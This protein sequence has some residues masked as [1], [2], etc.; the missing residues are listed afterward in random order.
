MLQHTI[1]Q[2]FSWSTQDRFPFIPSWV[3]GLW[4]VFFCVFFFIFSDNSCLGSSSP[5]RTHSRGNSSVI[6]WLSS[7]LVCSSKASNHLLWS[8]ERREQMN[9]LRIS[10]PRKKSLSSSCLASEKGFGMLLYKSNLFRPPYT[11]PP[12]IQIGL[13]IRS[14]QV[15]MF[16][17]T[18][19]TVPISSQ[20]PND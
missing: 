9:L 12:S 5:K 3:T 20:C 8:G 4:Q 1:S 14:A 11:H 2:C 17:W 18:A 15:L 6:A 16:A 7:W 19:A 10:S 13:V